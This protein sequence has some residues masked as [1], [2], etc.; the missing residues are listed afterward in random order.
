MFSAK[1]LLLGLLRSQ[2]TGSRAHRARRGFGGSSFG[3]VGGA[4]LGGLVSRALESYRERQSPAASH[5]AATLPAESTSAEEAEATNL[6]HLMI[7][8]AKADGEISPAE[9]Q[10]IT[11]ELVRTGADDEERAFFQRALDEPLDLDTVL[12]RIDNPQM[13]EE[14][15]AASLL[16]IE[17]DTPAEQQYLAYLATRLKL[18]DKTITRIHEQF[19]APRPL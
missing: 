15:Y 13:A 18:D 7:L 5:G 9:R 6:I 1:R 11:E 12:R 17:I 19:D 3:G 10:R 16:A 4:L 14:A 2:M 8:A